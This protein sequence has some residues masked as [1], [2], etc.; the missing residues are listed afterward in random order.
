MR[1]T[2]RRS[3][4]PVLAILIVLFATAPASAAIRWYE[5]KVTCQKWVSAS[6]DVKVGGCDN[7]CFEGHECTM[8]AGWEVREGWGGSGPLRQAGTDDKVKCCDQTSWC[9]TDPKY[10]V[11]NVY[12]NCP[13]NGCPGH[14]YWK[15]LWAYHAE[16]Y[17]CAPGPTSLDVPIQRL[18]VGTRTNNSWSCGSKC[19]NSDTFAQKGSTAFAFGYF[20]DWSCDGQNHSNKD[21]TMTLNSACGNGVC[22]LIGN[23]HQY[24]CPEDCTGCDGSDPDCQE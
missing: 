7:K 3:T 2:R 19:N 1:N 11:C 23:E 16:L 4:R 15:S 8:C 17:Q 18:A 22:E 9:G 21:C 5:Y 24:N 12:A 6:F 10:N 20:A 14:T 13:A